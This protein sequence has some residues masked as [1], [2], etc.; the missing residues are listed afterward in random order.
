MDGQ[1]LELAARLGRHLTA[2]GKTITTAESC[3]GGG[4]A[5]AI[6]EIA[7]SS[8]WFGRGFVTYSNLAKVQ[9]LGVDPQVIERYGAVSE[10]TV[11]AMVIGALAHS[12]AS[13]AIAIT[14]VAGPEGGS[15]D[16]PV[17]TVFIAWKN[18]GGIPIVAKQQF[19]GDRHQIR[20]QSVKIALE[21]AL[22]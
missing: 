21:G 1:L 12:D 7:G 18:K 22:R 2:Q 13:C 16:K 20:A 14:G 3:T 11:T 6:T 9:M 15:P 10:E 8:V 5:Q 4:L 17:G 19:S